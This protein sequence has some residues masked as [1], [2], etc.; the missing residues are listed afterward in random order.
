MESD[1]VYS[2]A[3]DILIAFIE[4]TQLLPDTAE[5]K[6]VAEADL[7]RKKISSR[8]IEVVK[9]PMHGNV[10]RCQAAAVRPGCQICTYMDHRTEN[11]F[12]HQLNSK[13]ILRLSTLTA[14]EIESDQ[15][16]TPYGPKPYVKG[17]DKEN[18]NSSGRCSTARP[19]LQLSE[20][21][22]DRILLD[23]GTTSHIT[24]KP[25]R[26]HSHNDFDV[27]IKLADHSTLEDISKGVQM[28]N[29]KTKSW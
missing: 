8:L 11:Y 19:H 25:D 14:T 26:V 24:S 16:N 7:N 12:I 5:I 18:R 22:P 20:R 21:V 4:V 27:A 2:L 23:S 10:P 13:N 3:I 9:L 28:L 1:F 29:W 17:G 15:N 6:T